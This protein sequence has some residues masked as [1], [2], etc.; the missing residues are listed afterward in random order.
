M[1]VRRIKS[2]GGVYI[3]AKPTAFTLFLWKGGG[4]E[5]RR[6]AEPRSRKKNPLAV[7]GNEESGKRAFHF[8]TRAA[9]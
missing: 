1:E 3:R 8:K 2:E 9:L 4:P 7:H 6:L 5:G